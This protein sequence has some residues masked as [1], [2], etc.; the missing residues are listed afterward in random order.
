[1]RIGFKNPYRQA[2]TQHRGHVQ[3]EIDGDDLKIQ[4]YQELSEIE[5]SDLLELINECEGAIANAQTFTEKLQ[6]NLG[7]LDGDNMNAIMESDLAIQ[8]LMKTLEAAIEDV[9]RFGVFSRN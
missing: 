1:M 7:T 4:D 5:Q 9:T 3:P 2:Q 8:K 6:T